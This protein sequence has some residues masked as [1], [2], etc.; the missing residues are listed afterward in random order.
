MSA[1][2]KLQRDVLEAL[3]DDATLLT[4][5]VDF[6]RG[7][8]AEMD[9]PRLLKLWE[10]ELLHD[11]GWEYAFIP[12]ARQLR[13]ALAAALATLAEVRAEHRCEWSCG[14]PRHTDPSIRCPE[15]DVLCASCGQSMPCNTIRILDRSKS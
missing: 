2:D 6:A 3:A 4:I 10:I 5:T 7:V 14:N 9:E 11:A 13:A 8:L 1:R 12:E 15:C